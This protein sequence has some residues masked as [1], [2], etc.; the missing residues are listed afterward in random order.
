MSCTVLLNVTAGNIGPRNAWGGGTV[1]G[2]AALPGLDATNRASGKDVLYQ[3]VRWTGGRSSPVSVRS[4]AADRMTTCWLPVHSSVE[5]GE[6]VNEPV[7]CPLR[8]GNDPVAL[9]STVSVLGTP[10]TGLPRLVKHCDV[11]VTVPVRAKSTDV[12]VFPR[13]AAF[14]ATTRLLS[15]TVAV[16]PLT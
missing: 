6:T 12:T 7:V 2:P 11:V 13:P 3:P 15:S 14:H 10:C 5:I 16:G 9:T 8:T 4:N 1:K